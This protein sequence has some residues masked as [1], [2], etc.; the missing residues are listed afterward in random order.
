MEALDSW[1]YLSTTSTAE[2]PPSLETCN[3]VGTRLGNI[4]AGIY[5]DP[6]LL[7]KSQTL[8]DGGRPWFENPDTK[9][10][11]RDQVAGEVLPILRP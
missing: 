6:T 2:P 5:C 9:N 1:M 3:S 11:I 7:L 10:L 8:T 4:L